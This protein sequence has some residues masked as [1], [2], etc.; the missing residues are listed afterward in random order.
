M[1][2]YTNEQV[3][4]KSA[5]WEKDAHLLSMILVGISIVSFL[6]KSVS[7]YF[8]FVAVALILSSAFC[9]TRLVVEKAKQVNAAP[10]QA[11]KLENTLS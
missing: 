8:I 5:K 6:L 3:E 11:V 7:P 10:V 4:K 9:M 2:N 1:K